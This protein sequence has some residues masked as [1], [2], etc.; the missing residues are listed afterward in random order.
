MIH[1]F[2]E[3]PDTLRTKEFF[4]LMKHVWRCFKE[5]GWE[6]WENQR[7]T[8]YDSNFVFDLL[9]HRLNESILTAKEVMEGKLEK[10]YRILT[11]TLFPPIVAI[12]ADSQVGT[13]KLIFGFS[14]DTTYTIIDDITEEIIY[15]VNCSLEDGLPVDWYFIDYKE[16]IM[17]R[18]HLKYGHKLREIPKKTKN[19][20]NSSKIMIDI[21]KDIRNERAPNRYSS[22][23]HIG[24]TYLT[25]VI[26]SMLQMSNFESY[27]GFWDGIQTTNK[28]IFRMSD[29]M[30]IFYPWPP[31][32]SSLM[33]AGR[34]AFI[35]KWSMWAGGRLYVNHIEEIILNWLKES[36]P[37]LYKIG[38]IDQ[39]QEGIPYPAQSLISGQTLKRIII[40][41]GNI[42]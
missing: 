5:L 1:N 36:N 22:S 41:L 35:S 17:D 13:M 16:E 28:K 14:I 29:L 25:P 15:L 40:N 33:L 27:G 20:E 23:Y 9:K 31:I 2:S 4:P 24:A 30:F 18:R 37:E 38:L 10:P 32:M 8:V 6:H 3:I 19:I 21:L 26:N 11:Y 39:I 42:F 34:R 12:R 7:Q